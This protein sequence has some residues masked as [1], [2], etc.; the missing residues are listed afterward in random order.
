M[1]VNQ[2]KAGAFL[3]YISIALHNIIGLLYTPFMLR[4]LGQSEYGL[5]SLVESVVAY[6]TILD[7]GFG[8][9]IIR[10]TAKFRAEGKVQEQWEMFGMFFMLYMVIGI[11]SF[12]AGLILYFNTDSMFSNTMDEEE[13][14]KINVMMLLM[15]FNIAFTFPMSI[16]GAIITA[17][18]NFVF[19]KIVGIVRIILNPAVMIVLLLIGYKAIAMVVATTIFNVVTLLINY[20]YC[21]NKLQIKV[22]FGHFKWGFFKEVSIYSFGCF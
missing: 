21:K 6:L 13:M 5:Y 10:Y 2:L 4:M 7:L 9:A 22:R 15:V 12:A 1:V 19:Q 18:E 17:Y 11:V 16:W 20:W 3:S 8:N 14:Y